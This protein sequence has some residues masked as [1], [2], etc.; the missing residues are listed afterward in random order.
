MSPRAAHYSVNALS[1]RI[2]CY[3]DGFNWSRD[4]VRNFVRVIYG[5]A[6]DRAGCIKMTQ[7]LF[8]SGLF[9][10]RSPQHS[11]AHACT[12]HTRKYVMFCLQ[13]RRTRVRMPVI[14]TTM[15]DKL[16]ATRRVDP[17]GQKTCRTKLERVVELDALV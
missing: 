4:T 6:R 8:C 10:T 1:T 12:R 3:T 13:A 11:A 2:R 5:T 16:L 15:A 7:W 17:D 14:K 9:L